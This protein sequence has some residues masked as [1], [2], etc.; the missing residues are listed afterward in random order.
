MNH[1]ALLPNDAVIEHHGDVRTTSIKIAEAFGKRHDDV[2][3][4]L[5]SLDCS[6]DFTDRN[7]TASEYR[8]S[9]GRKL[10][11]WE[12]TK[13][14]FMFLVMGFTGKK[15]AAI[16]EAYIERF[17]AMAQRLQQLS[18]SIAIT[19]K[20]QPPKPPRQ[21]ASY[22]A[23]Y[24]LTHTPLPEYFDS[25]WIPARIERCHV[26]T[27]WIWHVR[28]VV[29][30]TASGKHGA[31]ISFGIGNQDGTTP[32]FTRQHNVFSLPD[33]N[34]VFRNID[35]LWEN[36]HEHLAKYNASLDIRQ[37]RMNA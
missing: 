10:P 16:K 7:F 33:V 2:L 12:I 19:H 5:K 15:A 25:N 31:C 17:N 1:I 6:A 3:R 29:Q 36:I 34:L 24:K 11:M 37:Y 28:V 4:K 23:Q 8:D 20:N 30:P 26:P 22:Q 14:G 18:A 21:Y 35:E 9:T 13:D 27:F 32:R